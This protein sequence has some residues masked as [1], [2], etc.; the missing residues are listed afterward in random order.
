VLIPALALGPPQ[1][2]SLV[3]IV[4]GAFLG[5]GEDLV[6]GLDVG[7]EGGGAIRVAIVAVGVEF[8]GLFA[9]GFLDSGR[10]SVMVV[11]CGVSG[12]LFVGGC[13]FN[14]QQLVVA[15]LDVA[16]RRTSTRPSASVFGR[17]LRAHL[18]HADACRTVMRYRG[19]RRR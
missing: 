13:S 7:E 1:Y 12:A 19:T 11:E 3:S 18:E 8:E 14:A 17:L 15:R 9:V 5:I 6:G 10:V 4:P 16:I 2:V